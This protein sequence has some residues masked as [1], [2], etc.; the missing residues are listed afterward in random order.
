M[1]PAYKESP[2]VYFKG[3]V[4]GRNYKEWTEYVRGAAAGRR[5]RDAMKE[6]IKNDKRSA[7]LHPAIKTPVQAPMLRVCAW[8]TQ[9]GS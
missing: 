3:V 9:F 6:R 7:P 1:R 2:T 4:G 5:T 8:T